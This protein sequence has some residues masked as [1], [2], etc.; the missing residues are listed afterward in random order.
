MLVRQ[1]TMDDFDQLTALI[2]A[3]AKKLIEKHVFQWSYPCELEQLESQIINGEV[4]ILE[5]HNRLIGSYSIKPVEAHFP[6][7]ID[8]S[9]YV[10]R[11]LVH[12][13]YQGKNMTQHMF[14]HLRKEYKKKPVLTDCWA[15]ND[16]LSQF[17]LN[18][19]CLHLGDFPEEDYKVSI[20]QIGKKGNFIKDNYGNFKKI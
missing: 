11:M 8:K 15:G 16:K 17:Y 20:F 9:L 2:Q 14:K 7:Q 5:D 10:Y 19:D 1:A 13:F 3:T 18:H 12:P 4:F 6:V